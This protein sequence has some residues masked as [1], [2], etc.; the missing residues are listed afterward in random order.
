M[1]LSQEFSIALRL[2]QEG[3][4]DQAALHY[5]AILEAQPSHFDAMHL[6][7]VVR[8]QQGR[9]T[10]GLDKIQSALKLNPTNVE[11]LSNLGL[12][13]GKLGR[14]AEAL[15]SYDKALAIMPGHALVLN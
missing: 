14:P 13:L 9:H 5:A 8:L 11:A 10:E 2:H 12:G 7:G 15:A 6:L 3:K 1:N 4:L